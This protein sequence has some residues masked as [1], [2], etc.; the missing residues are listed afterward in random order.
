MKKLFLL[1][2]PIIILSSCVES[3]ESND[4][5][6][7]NI[8]L[9]TLDGVRWQEVFNGVDLDLI[10]NKKILTDSNTKLAEPRF[11]T[12]ENIYNVGE[13]VKDYPNFN[14]INLEY[15]REPDVTLSKDTLSGNVK[16]YD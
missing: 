16:F 6:A 3:R 4:N 14:E 9:I 8:I 7:P 5:N 1:L 12:A 13:K 15:M 2:I 11:V 10:E